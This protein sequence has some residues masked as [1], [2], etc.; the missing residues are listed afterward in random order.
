MPKSNNNRNSKFSLSRDISDTKRDLF[1]HLMFIFLS[2][3]RFEISIA[4]NILSTRILGSAKRWRNFMKYDVRALF[5]FQ[6][7]SK[8]L[9]TVYRSFLKHVPLVHT[10]TV[11]L[12]LAKQKWPEKNLLSKWKA[13][14]SVRANAREEKLRVIYVVFPLLLF[15]CAQFRLSVTSPN[16]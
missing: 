12:I 14:N 16:L 15:L 10:K 13:W 5:I 4:T 7:S 3:H 2:I 6:W 11:A 8:L 1:T 9:L